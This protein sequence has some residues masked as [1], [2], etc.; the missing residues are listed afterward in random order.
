MTQEDKQLLLKDLCGRFPND[1]W[2]Q[3]EGSDYLVTGYGHGRVSLL[4]SKYSSSVGPCPLVEEV[5]P[6]LRSLKTMTWK[7]FCESQI[8]KDRIDYR[9]DTD[10]FHFISLVT[11]DIEILD[12]LNEHM[13]DFRDL[14]KKGLAIEVTEEN[15]PY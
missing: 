12:W 9:I 8:S 5:K 11:F 6:Y 1:I 14:I 13:F 2:I 3:W 4:P 7:E 15:N 10:G